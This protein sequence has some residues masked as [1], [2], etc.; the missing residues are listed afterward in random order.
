MPLPP[1]DPGGNNPASSVAA[2]VAYLEK[3]FRSMQLPQAFSR[4]SELLKRLPDAEANHAA[5]QAVSC[6]TAAQND[7]KSLSL[8]FQAVIG[9]VSAVAASVNTVVRQGTFSV[10]FAGLAG[11]RHGATVAATWVTAGSKIYYQYANAIPNPTFDLEKFVEWTNAITPGV[12][13]DAFAY[14][15]GTPPAASYTFNWFS[16]G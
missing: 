3:L 13:F 12:S 8:G 1:Y 5:Q 4:L 7:M 2:A 11:E 15:V 16:F 9:N 14:N 6:A 10:T